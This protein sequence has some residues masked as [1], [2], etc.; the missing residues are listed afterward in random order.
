MFPKKTSSFVYLLKTSR[1]FTLVEAMV[2]VA[3]LGLVA[4]GV[5]TPYVA[6]LRALD[7]Q[8]ESMML[9]SRLRSRM[10][11]LV[12]TDFGVLSSGSEAVTVNGQNFTINWTVVPMDLDGDTNP[13]PSAVR[14]TVSVTQRPNHSLTTLRVNNEGRVGK[15]S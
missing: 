7:V 15:I 4:V 11:A 8:A 2:S 6:G 12:G 14:V 3:L 5:A 1:G 13:D 9:D 10:E